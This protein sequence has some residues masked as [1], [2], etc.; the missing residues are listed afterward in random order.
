VKQQ[1]TDLLVNQG[2]IAPNRAPL[3]TQA[4]LDAIL[5]WLAAGPADIVL[6]SLEDL[7]QETQPQNTPGTFLERCNWRRKARF[8]LE[9]LMQLP[10]ITNVLRTIDTLRKQSRA[11]QRESAA[12]SSTLPRRPTPTR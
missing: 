9:H 7:W 11:L 2:L 12:A 8:T 10:D 5:K 6:I 4:A 1:V 3:D